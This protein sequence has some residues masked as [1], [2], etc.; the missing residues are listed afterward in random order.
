[1]IAKK[2]FHSINSLT[3]IYQLVAELPSKKSEIEKKINSILKKN[4]NVYP[5]LNDLLVLEKKKKDIM[6]FTKQ[7]I[8]IVRWYLVPEYYLTCHT[9]KRKPKH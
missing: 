2:M 7:I 4:L 9:F 1:M 5:P 6:L 3:K 8:I